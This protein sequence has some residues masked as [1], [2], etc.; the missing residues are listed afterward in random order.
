MGNLGLSQDWTS[1]SRGEASL[2][3]DSNL[4]FR[5]YNAG[6][7]G[8]HNRFC[9][10]DA[11]ENMGSIVAILVVR[12]SHVH[13]SLRAPSDGGLAQPIACIVDDRPDVYCNGS[14]RADISQERMAIQSARVL[15]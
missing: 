6:I 9:H 14:R 7:H 15:E 2:L 8:I 5:H 3:S 1:R 4:G 13:R 12:F 10:L 11:A